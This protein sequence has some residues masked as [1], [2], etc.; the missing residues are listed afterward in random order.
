[1]D[2][3]N[4]ISGA[5]AA[6]IAPIEVRRRQVDPSLFQNLI[7]P[8]SQRGDPLRV[9]DVQPIPA[10]IASFLF[11]SLPPGICN[12][13]AGSCPPN[14]QPPL[15]GPYY[16]TGCMHIG[17]SVLLA[18]SVCFVLFRV[19]SPRLILSH[20][21][22]SQIIFWTVC[23]GHLRIPRR[24]RCSRN[25]REVPKYNHCSSHYAISPSSAMA[26][27]RYLLRYYWLVCLL[28]YSSVPR[29][30]T[31]NPGSKKKKKK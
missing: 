23:F 25:V 9:C 1:M 8:F 12:C 29:D 15:G 20:T 17:D 30:G 13:A 18:Q 14:G 19:V 26:T 31:Q 27:S 4:S 24:L 3:L 22:L 28:T 2:E 5:E 11:R 16:C 10:T 21:F 7:A 6:G